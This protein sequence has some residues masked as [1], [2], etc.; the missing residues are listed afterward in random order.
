M[1]TIREL[2]SVSFLSVSTVWFVMLYHFSIESPLTI[3]RTFSHTPTVV[4]GGGGV[5]RTP[6]EFDML[7]FC[8]RWKAFDLLYKRRYILWVV[9]L[10]KVCDV[11]KNGR[12]LDRHLGFYQELEIR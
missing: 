5:D 12:H 11:T 4:Q 10:L 8:L 9:A 1:E 2:I 7:Q 6:L 3:G